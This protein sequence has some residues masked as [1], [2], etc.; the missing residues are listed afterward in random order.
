MSTES[1][2]PPHT[3]M[4]GCLLR[5]AWMFAGNTAALF[6]L[7][8]VARGPARSL[9]LGD[10]VYALLIASLVLLRYLDIRCYAGETAAGGEPATLAHWRRYT[11]VVLSLATLAWLLVRALA[12]LRSG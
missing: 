9:G 12:W 7:V 5:L 1:P 3:P 6:C 4:M 10:L 8:Y 2:S 11:A